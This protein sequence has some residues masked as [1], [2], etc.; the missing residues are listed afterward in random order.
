MKSIVDF[1]V[2]DIE[3]NRSE[4][5][6]SQGVPDEASLSGN[7]ERV[8]EEAFDLYREL[9]DPRGKFRET[10]RTAFEELLL[11]DGLNE[12]DC[13]V[14]GIFRRGDFLVMFAVTLGEELSGRVTGLFDEGEYPTGYM[15]DSISSCAA[16]NL[17]DLAAKVFLSELAG[18]RAVS[19]SMLAYS[20][21]YCGWHISGQR[22]LFEF[23]QPGEIFLLI[24]KQGVIDRRDD[25]LHG[26]HPCLDHRP[27]L[28]GQRNEQATGVLF[29]NA[30]SSHPGDPQMHLLQD[31][32]EDLA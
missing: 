19:L 16:D 15:L 9:A 12:P 31:L 5:L 22:K 30:W 27:L 23:L 2:E 17:V 13:P 28:G 32:I 25:R 6:R 11:G 7:F 8:Y 10:G 20:P 4:V 26:G 24:V 21:G 29:G 14:D 1:S 3:L 18:D